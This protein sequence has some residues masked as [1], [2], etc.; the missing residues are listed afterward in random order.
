MPVKHQNMMCACCNPLCPVWHPKPL[1]NNMSH[2]LPVKLQREHW[3]EGD[4]K[5]CLQVP[6]FDKEHTKR[7]QLEHHQAHTYSVEQ[8]APHHATTL[9]FPLVDIAQVVTPSHPCTHEPHHTEWHQ[10]WGHHTER[11]CDQKHQHDVTHLKAIA[12]CPR[13]VCEALVAICEKNHYQQV[14]T[15]YYDATVCQAKGLDTLNT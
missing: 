3:H 1:L 15:A 10:K 9:I 7:E 8:V 11:Q 5:E 14:R 2:S 4:H 13:A 12:W 6:A